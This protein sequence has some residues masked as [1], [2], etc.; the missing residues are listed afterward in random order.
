M[1]KSCVALAF[2]FILCSACIHAIGVAQDYLPEN[3]L[4]LTP[5]SS[6]IF[7]ITLQNENSEELHV[8]LVLN[9]D[10]AVIVNPKPYYLIPGKF[11]NTKVY[12]NISISKETKLN[13]QYAV[14]YYV[15]PLINS[16][17]AMIPLNLRINKQFFVKVVDKNYTT[18]QPLS[19]KIEQPTISGNTI[20][21]KKPQPEKTLM[22]TKETVLNLYLKGAFILACILLILTF[23]WKKSALLSNKVIKRNKIGKVKKR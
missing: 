4:F 6:Y 9:S 12:V 14:G 21:E 18:E 13:T 11:Y 16:S 5:G 15:Q 17:G 8:K 20:E 2:L 1:K 23:I 22:V 7:T 19:Q 10:I 3:T